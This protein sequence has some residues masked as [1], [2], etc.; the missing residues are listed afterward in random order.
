MIPAVVDLPPAPIS[1]NRRHYDILRTADAIKD[2]VEYS[3]A[4]AAQAKT[5]K[6]K[7]LHAANNSELSDAAFR[8]LFTYLVFAKDDGSDSYPSISKVSNVT[9]RSERSS[10]RTVKELEGAGW[11]ETQRKRRGAAVRKA[12]IP[13]A[14]SKA[15]LQKFLEQTNMADLNGHLEVPNLS[16]PELAPV[17]ETPKS[18]PR[19]AKSG[20]PIITSINQGSSSGAPAHASPDKLDNRD[21]EDYN[22]LFNSWG[23]KPGTNMFPTCRATTDALLDGVLRSQAKHPVDLAVEAVRSTTSLMIGKIEMAPPGTSGPTGFPKYH[24]KVLLACVG[25]LI[26]MQ[27]QATAPPG[28]HQEAWQ[29]EKD[30]KRET[31]KTILGILQKSEGSSKS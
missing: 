14:V 15:I 31:A 19:T 8:M 2:Q 20:A 25:E 23:R 12:S 7:L 16:P 29:A 28:H 26:E 18:V 24:H 30:R 1:D 27:K 3:N 13:E 17:Q 21:Y 11:L 5:Y 6:W 9:R 22:K 10:A 4:F